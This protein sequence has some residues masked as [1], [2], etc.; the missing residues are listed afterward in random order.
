MLIILYVWILDIFLY[1]NTEIFLIFFI[2]SSFGIFAYLVLVWSRKYLEELIVEE[3]K[4]I[5]TNLF[6][7]REKFTVLLSQ[8]HFKP[9][10]LDYNFYPVFF[11]I[12]NNFFQ[13][14]VNS[15]K[16]KF[17]YKNYKRWIKYVQVLLIN[18]YYSELRNLRSLVSKEFN[19]L[20]E[21][22]NDQ[23]SISKTTDPD[24][25]ILIHIENFAFLLTSQ[26]THMSLF[27][28]IIE[29]FRSFLSNLGQKYMV[30]PS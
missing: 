6:I 22:S 29:N 5:Y 18:L 19:Q 27:E 25:M 8:V 1:S 14:L 17:F 10:S 21:S 13:I 4:G 2:F 11:N 16:I 24:K 30:F 26:V 23:S 20:I 15:E 7:I 3:N 12:L 9:S 28:L